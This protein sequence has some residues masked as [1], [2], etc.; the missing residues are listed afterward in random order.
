MD[1]SFISLTSENDLT[2]IFNTFLMEYIS[3]GGRNGGQ[4][5]GRNGDPNGGLNG[6]AN[7]TV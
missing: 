6:C 4:N 3:H 2:A 1:R 7:F 5:V